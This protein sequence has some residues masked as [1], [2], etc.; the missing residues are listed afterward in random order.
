M[1][2]SGSALHELPVF[3][4]DDVESADAARN[5]NANFVEIVFG[6][7]R[8]FAILV[9]KSAAARAIWMK[10]PIFFSSFFSIQRN[11]SKFLTSP[12]IVQ[13]KPVVSKSVMVPT[14]VLAGDDIFP[15]FVR[16]DSERANQPDA[17]HNDPASHRIMLPDGW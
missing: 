8:P 12:A 14:P 4:L 15:G 17:C 7:L 11:G 13:S 5:V 6:I 1:K 2:F 9:A 3:S 10:R 16:A